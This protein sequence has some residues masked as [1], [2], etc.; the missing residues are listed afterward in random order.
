MG[1]IRCSSR[2]KNV[3]LP[4]I[5]ILAQHQY[6]ETDLGVCQGLD[7]RELMSWYIVGRATFTARATLQQEPCSINA[8]WW[9]WDPSGSTGIRLS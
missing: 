8:P 1:D 4:L 2:Q 6:G 3:G 9:H 7:W 5:N